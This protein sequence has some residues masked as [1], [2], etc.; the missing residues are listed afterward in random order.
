MKLL[1]IPRV[2]RA[3]KLADFLNHTPRE[4]ELAVTDFRQ[5]QPGDGSPVSQPTTAYLSYDDK[6][7]YI[8]YVCKDDPKLI[9]AR[10]AK[11][12]QILRDDRVIL[13]IDTFHDHKH[14]YWFDFNPYGVQMDGNVTDGVED[15]PSWDTLW[16]TDGRLTEDGYAVL[17]S[18]PFKSIRFPSNKE[19]TWGLVLGRFIQRNNEFSV[20]PYISSRKPGWVQ[21]GG[22]MEGIRDIS[23][24]RNLQFIPYGLFSGARFLD[25]PPDGTPRFTTEKDA[26]VGIDS[27][28]VLKDAFTLDLT[29]N[30]DFS[31][32]ESDEPQVTVNQRYEVYFPEKRPF[33]LEN[34]GYFKTP[35]QL[36]FSRR[37]V[38]PAFGARLTGRVGK[39]SVGAL[40]ADDRAPGKGVP[41]FD[42][43]Y[44]AHSPVG[45]VRVQRDFR[46]S[47]RTNTIAAMATSQDF[48]ATY[49][50]VFSLDTRMQVLRNW[51]FTGQAMSSNTRLMD[52]RR[53]AGPGYYASWSH[54][55]RHLVSST[56]YTD[57]N[58]NFRSQT[59]FVRRV[60]VRQADQQLGYLWRP[61]SGFIQSF[62]PVFSGQAIY[63]RQGRLTD[64][65]LS[66]EI[67]L[68]MTRRTEV[69]FERETAYEYYGGTGFRKYQN[70]L[71]FGTEWYRWLTVSGEVVNGTGINYSPA[72]GR[73]P[74]LGRFREASATFTLRPGPRLQLDETYIYS[75]MRTSPESN[76]TGVAEGTAVFNNHLVRSKA[77]YNF[78]RRAS[79]RFILDYNSVLPNRALANLDKEKRIGLDA[80]FTY[81]VNPGTALYIGYTDLYENYKLNPLLSPALYRT[82]YPDLNTG[83]QFF[84]K[85]SYL[86]RF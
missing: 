20:W 44:K 25:A 14:M 85:L 82:T 11:H 39:W 29:L 51:I 34:A 78:S 80:L 31:Q 4:A 66:P 77:N 84:V 81:M 37:I 59:G 3:P 71:E 65:N 19:Q 68:S 38:D 49:N 58:P 74:F 60:D 30:P 72:G 42:P 45:V 76:L 52:G 47:G 16:H 63:D 55:G 57:F 48:G 28:V 50:R 10:V 61:E 23:P 46:R 17:A 36:L 13:N 33:F 15:D 1:R 5:Y 73:R 6:N 69:M 9:R 53:L 79:L 75:G 7:L 22:D 26:R 12:D 67:R 24:G 35:V 32:V 83:R 64:W 70:Q 41:E 2:K 27:K 56:T 18:V 62:G 40:F 8:A 54:A 86:F 21:Q 43:A